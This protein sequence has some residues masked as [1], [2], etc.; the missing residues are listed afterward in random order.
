MSAYQL[1]GC[2]EHS[3]DAANACHKKEKGIARPEPERMIGIMETHF[4]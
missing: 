1:H 4:S 3:E 2:K